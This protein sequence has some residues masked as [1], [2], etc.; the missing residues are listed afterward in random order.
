MI[1]V[2]GL[3]VERGGTT[4][5]DGYGFTIAR[6]SVAA[7]LGANG[8]GKTSLINTI[9]GLLPAARGTVRCS[10]RIGYVPQLFDVAFDYSVTD[11]VLMGRA[12]KIG[13]FG[14]PRAADYA[15]VHRQLQALGI[16]HLAERSFNA[17]S[18]GQRQLVVIA[19][20]LVSDCEILI[21]DEPCSA[22]D[23]R[24]QALVVGVLD[25]LRREHGMTVLFTTHAPQHALEIAT[26]VLL[27]YGRN[28]FF[29]GSTEEALSEAALA[30]L[31]GVA[32]RKAHFAHS[33][34]FTYAPVFGGPAA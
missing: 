30:R 19:Q 20:A 29:Y 34:G 1:E 21:L 15:A 11:I 23:Y 22:L 3:S 18:G 10:A 17:L 33:D 7:I 9:A 4:I 31:Y 5:L 28:D 14:S 24:N 6:G 32:V 26:D 2:S 25:R 13:L 12:R 8:V 16:E 27:M